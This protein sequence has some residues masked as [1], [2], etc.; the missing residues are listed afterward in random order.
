MTM[1]AR[2]TGLALAALVGLAV[3]AHAEDLT[4]RAEAA[5]KTVEARMIAW[6][7]DIHAHP[8]LGDTETRT[9]AGR[10]PLA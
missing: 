5:A 10:R 7:R 2:M 3:P 8:E 1:R 9:A 4:T 6:R